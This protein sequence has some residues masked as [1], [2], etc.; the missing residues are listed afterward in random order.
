MTFEAF[1]TAYASF[2]ALRPNLSAEDLVMTDT[3]SM[4]PGNVMIISEF[5]APCI[6]CFTFPFNTFLA[7]ISGMQYNCQLG[8]MFLCS[9]NYKLLQFVKMLIL[10]ALDNCPLKNRN[11]LSSLFFLVIT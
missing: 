10:V 5:T 9:L 4:L 2:P 7:L 6:T 3:T 1:I 11:L 8:Y